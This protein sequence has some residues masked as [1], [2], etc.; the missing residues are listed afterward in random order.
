[1]MDL[2]LRLHRPN[3]FRTS[4]YANVVPYLTVCRLS[5]LVNVPLTARE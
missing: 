2:E 3:P 4:D 1:M 5:S